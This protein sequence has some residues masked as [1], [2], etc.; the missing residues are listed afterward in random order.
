MFFRIQ[1]QVLGLKRLIGGGLAGATIQAYC[2]L[3]ACVLLTHLTGGRVTM[4]DYRMMCLYV[5]GWADD[6]ELEAYLAQRR[7]KDPA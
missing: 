2:A 1:K 7:N 4:A 5:Q 3:I 6:E